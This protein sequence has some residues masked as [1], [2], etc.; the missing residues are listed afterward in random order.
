MSSGHDLSILG[1]VFG[2]KYAHSFYK[3]LF[4]R[5]VDHIHCLKPT[6]SAWSSV[7]LS[8]KALWTGIEKFCM[9]YDG[10]MER[11]EIERWAVHYL[12]SLC[13]FE[14]G[15]FIDPPLVTFGLL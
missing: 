4:K 3:L 11:R 10:G 8:C 9:E 15:E 1:Q 12:L 7:K 6:C 14:G 5:W 2:T 13:T